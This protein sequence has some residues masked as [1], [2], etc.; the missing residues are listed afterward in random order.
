[1]VYTLIGVLL[2]WFFL[3]L[4]YLSPVVVFYRHT[5]EYNLPRVQ[6]KGHAVLAQSDDRIAPFAWKAI[7][8]GLIPYVLWIYPKVSVDFEEDPLLIVNGG[9]TKYHVGIDQSTG[10]VTIY[11]FNNKPYPVELKEGTP[12]GH[13]LFARGRGTLTINL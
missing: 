2:L 3:W 6:H 11:L 5:Y 13:L 1:M 4:R 12:L 9:L 7:P 10:E 8:T